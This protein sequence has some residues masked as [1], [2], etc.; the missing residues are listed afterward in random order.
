MRGPGRPAALAAA[1]NEQLAPAMLRPSSAFPGG[2]RAVVTA[3]DSPSRC[4]PHGARAPADESLPAAG[5][6]GAGSPR[7]HVVRFDASGRDASGRPVDGRGLSSSC[8]HTR[9]RGLRPT[10]VTSVF[11]SL[12]RR[13]HALGTRASVRARRWRRRCPV[14]AWLAARRSRAVLPCGSR[15]IRATGANM[16]TEPLCCRWSGR[17]TE[18]REAA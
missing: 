10:I 5:Q 7:E 2:G 18:V 4:R 16:P 1:G 9:G 11:A 17:G 3:R 14:S 13:G 8:G 12:L 15:L 6:G